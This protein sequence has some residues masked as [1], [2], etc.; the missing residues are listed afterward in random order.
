MTPEVADPVDP[1]IDAVLDLRAAGPHGRR[2]D[3]DSDRARDH[4]QNLSDGVR[5]LVGPAARDAE[6]LR[7][8]PIYWADEGLR[9]KYGD[10]WGRDLLEWRASGTRH[11]GYLV[12]DDDERDG[13]NAG[14][15]VTAVWRPAAVPGFEGDIVSGSEKLNQDLP[16]SR[17]GGRPDP[18]RA[19]KMWVAGRAAGPGWA[20]FGR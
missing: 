15:D 20:A 18:A 6:L 12:Y 17:P 14:S 7:R 10:E 8:G 13:R 11:R 1:V 9:G 2:P 19:R 16:G 4:L 3:P 5:R